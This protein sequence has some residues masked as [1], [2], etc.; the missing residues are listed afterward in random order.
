MGEKGSW[1]QILPLKIGWRK[2]QNEASAADLRGAQQNPLKKTILEV[3]TMPDRILWKG[4][5]E[6]AGEAPVYE[7]LTS[8][9]LTNSSTSRGSEDCWEGPWF[10]KTERHQNKWTQGVH[11]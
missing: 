4:D 7:N 11:P 8:K 6:Y 1:G 3:Q 10:A 5:G 2:K 9:S